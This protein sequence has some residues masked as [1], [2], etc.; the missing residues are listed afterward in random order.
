MLAAS[1]HK[2][3]SEEETTAQQDQQPSKE[4]SSSRGSPR[5]TIPQIR[6]LVLQIR[7][8]RRMNQERDLLIR[9]IGV[10]VSFRKGWVKKAEV[11]KNSLNLRCAM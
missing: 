7:K 2:E 8:L 5:M 9:V 11:K 6:K 10:H 4:P 1:T 3:P